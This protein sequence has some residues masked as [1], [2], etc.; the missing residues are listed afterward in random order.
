VF[1]YLEFSRVVVVVV[2]GG[3][4]C[5]SS[6]GGG[7]GGGDGDG[8]VV[9]VVNMRMRWMC[10]HLAYCMSTCSSASTEP[11]TVTAIESFAESARRKLNTP[12]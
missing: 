6:G 3:G 10:A 7:G 1:R 2:G 4:G 5:S 11:H 8:T 9:V 12:P